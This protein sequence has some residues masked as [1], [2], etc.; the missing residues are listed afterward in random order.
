MLLK[1][2]RVLVATDIG[3]GYPPRAFILL[4]E[5]HVRSLHVIARHM[6][7]ASWPVVDIGL[8][9]LR[10]VDCGR[11]HRR[12]GRHGRQVSIRCFIQDM[13]FTDIHET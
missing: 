9:I 2:V 8:D 13:L 6:V 11:R 7:G 1:T 12:H 5:L 3:D 4:S 10:S